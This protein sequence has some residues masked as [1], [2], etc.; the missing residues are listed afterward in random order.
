MIELL[1]RFQF[2]RL[3]IFHLFQRFLSIFRIFGGSKCV[4]SVVVAVNSL[5]NRRIGFRSFRPITLVRRKQKNMGLR[6]R[7]PVVPRTFQFLKL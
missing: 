1:C 4:K 6:I 7:L 5:L 3:R 2:S